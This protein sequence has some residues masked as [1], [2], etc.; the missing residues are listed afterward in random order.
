MERGLR[1]IGATVLPTGV[2]N[3][4]IQAQIIL[5]LGVTGFIGSPSFLFNI[6][7]RI[8]PLGLEKLRLKRAVLTAEM[9]SA[10]DKKELG[11]YGIVAMEGYGTA[12]TG[13][14][15][16]ECEEKNGFHIA[17]G[18]FAEIVDPQS[19][20]RVKDGEIGEVVVTTFNPIYPL[21]RFGTGDLSSIYHSTCECGRTSARLGRI[22]GRVGGKAAKVRGMFIHPGQIG[23]LV[24][25]TSGIR[26][27]QL[28]ITQIGRN[29]NLLLKVETEGETAS[30]T[31]QE[32][33]KVNFR[34]I[35]RLKLDSLQFC[36]INEE[37]DLI[38]DKRAWN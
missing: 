31:L 11:G 27:S 38:V 23:K 33:I 15:G 21:I 14:F 20:E 4:E 2:G 28:V 10:S 30:G 1:K 37:E 5:E 26:K 12:E 7:E 3:T 25:C 17:Q 8:E 6:L 13:F 35:C 9:I 32:A 24:S 22:L 19:G 29:D 18:I 34:E 16:Y 36:S